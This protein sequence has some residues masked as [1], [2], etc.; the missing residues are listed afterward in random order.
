MRY[1]T[2]ET[3][4]EINDFIRNHPNI[5]NDIDNFFQD[6]IITTNLVD[7]S[8]LVLNVYGV[9]CVERHNNPNKGIEDSSKEQNQEELTD[10]KRSLN[11]ESNKL[12]AKKQRLLVKVNIMEHTRRKLEE[13]LYIKK[14][15]VK[16]DALLSI[17]I[18]E[19]KTIED[20]IEKSLNLFLKQ[21]G[22]KIIDELA[23]V[24][25]LINNHKD[26]IHQLE[27]TIREI[28]HFVDKSKLF[29]VDK[30]SEN[31]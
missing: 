18:Y 11:D 13:Q 25:T 10:V 20:N 27:T 21:S 8:N 1:V 5:R 4:D 23:E 17:D 30:G 14:L 2:P 24:N 7:F 6:G 9:Q 12:H 28:D 3:A 31:I 22:D 15:S 16:A 29:A 26:F 19:K